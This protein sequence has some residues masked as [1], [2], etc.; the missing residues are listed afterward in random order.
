MYTLNSDASA[1]SSFERFYTLHQAWVLALLVRLTRDRDRAA[2]LSQSVW[3]KIF[4]RWRELEPTIQGS[5]VAWLRV[6][7]LNAVY[8]RGRGLARRAETQLDID[9]GVGSPL[10][11][12]LPDPKPDPEQ[13]AC[14]NEQR[15]ILG[16]MIRDL[17]EKD[18]TLFELL[19]DR[20]LSTRQAAETMGCSVTAV[21][22]RWFRIKAALAA[23]ARENGLR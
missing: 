1:Q 20:K 21:V 23:V 14:D 2:D 13:S 4:S 9:P 19:V 12:R 7:V 3:L 18:R 5:G 16:Q 17:P 22:A 15:E 10:F 11:D 6:V 8:D